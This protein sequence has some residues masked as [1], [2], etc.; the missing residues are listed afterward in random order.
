VSKTININTGLPGFVLLDRLGEAAAGNIAGS[1]HFAAP[2]SLALAIESLAQLGA[3]HVRYLTNFEKHAF[4]LKI[5]SCPLPVSPM[6]AGI[7]TLSGELLGRSASAFTHLLRAKA[8]DETIMEGVFLFAV[9]D[10]DSTF[11]K[12]ILQKHYERVFSCLQKDIGIDC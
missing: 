9:V 10:Y 12:E 1:R 8:A 5:K 4:L 11:R 3:Y 6:P 2:P 7:Y